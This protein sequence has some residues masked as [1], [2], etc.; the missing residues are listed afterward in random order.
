[1]MSMRIVIAAALLVGFD[2]LIFV[3][4]AVLMVACAAGIGRLLW[5]LDGSPALDRPG[6]WPGATT[7]DGEGA[8]VCSRSRRARAAGA[9]AACCGAPLLLLAV[10]VSLGVASAVGIIAGMLVLGGVILWAVRTGRVGRRAR[11]HRP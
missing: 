11:A 5:L 3:L 8:A 10:V 2:A 1:M 4:L 6:W 9:C 7:A